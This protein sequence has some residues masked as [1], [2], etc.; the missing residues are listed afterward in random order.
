MSK[1]VAVIGAGFAGLST[2][3]LLK[4]LGYD[5]TIYEKDAEVGGVWASSR[6]Y[7]G[8]GTQNPGSTYALSEHPMPKKY[9]EWPSGEQMQTY[10]ESYVDRFGFRA[11]IRFKTEVVNAE[12]DH[13]TWT[14]NTRETSSGKNGEEDVEYFDFLIVCNGIFSSPKIPHFDGSQEWVESGRKIMHTSDFLD[15]NDVKDKKVVVIGYGKSSCDAA[16]SIAKKAKETH[17]VARKIIWK[18]PKKIG[19]IINF[20]HLFL[21]RLG[22]GLFPYIELK[23]FDKVI[24]GVGKPVRKMLLTAIGGIISRQLNFKKCGLYPYGPLETIARTSISLATDGFF[25]KVENGSIAVHRDTQISKLSDGVVYLA[26][27]EKIEADIIIAGTGFHQ[28]IP[29][30]NKDLMQ[31][32]TK[33]NGDFKLYKQVIPVGVPGLAFVGYNSSF[34]S[35]LSCE[36]AAMFV[37]EYMRGGLNLPSTQEQ[38]KYVEKRLE[39][40]KERTDGNYFKGTYIVPFSLRQMDEL[41]DMMNLKLSK[42]TRFMQWFFVVDPSKY[43]VLYKELE[44]RNEVNKTVIKGVGLHEEVGR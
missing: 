27:G 25:E 20:K 29:F 41:L 32:V 24:H 36:T 33:E 9:P 14:I 17:V 5:V 2:G 43:S 8:L 21:T 28:E 30:F 26:N 42:F 23:G 40:A 1:R 44:K 19:G 35:Q 22:E 3:K 13:G 31:K 10:F 15:I 18:V 34:F 37:S 12:Y 39:W 7:P 6:R 38:E 16:N 4:N 11:I